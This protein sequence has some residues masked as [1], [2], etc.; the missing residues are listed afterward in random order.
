MVLYAN[1]SNVTTTYSFGSSTAAAAD[2]FPGRAV[3]SN[4]GSGWVPA[5]YIF[6]MTGKHLD[7]TSADNATWSPGGDGWLSSRI[8]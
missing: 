6:S 4:S 5:V 1:N 2:R 8:I 7:G 3:T